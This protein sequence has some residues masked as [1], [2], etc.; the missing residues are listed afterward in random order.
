MPLFFLF[1]KCD[2]IKTIV[3]R[4][5][6]FFTWCHQYFINGEKK[7]DSKLTRFQK[8]LGKETVLT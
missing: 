7:L 1:Q 6:S 3:E 2:E 4:K 5:K 8:L